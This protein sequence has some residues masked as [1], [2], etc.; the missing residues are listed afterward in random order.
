MLRE[1]GKIVDIP[2]FSHVTAEVAVEYLSHRKSRRLMEKPSNILLH[3]LREASEVDMQELVDY[4]S[5]I[6]KRYLDRDNVA[7]IFH[8]AYT[9]RGGLPL[10]RVHRIY[11]WP[12]IWSY[13]R[14]G[15]GAWRFEPLFP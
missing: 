14:G 11:Q 3:I 12:A 2:E 15:R 5:A 10:K 6:Y 4:C 7:G 1:R 13:F 9:K 8:L